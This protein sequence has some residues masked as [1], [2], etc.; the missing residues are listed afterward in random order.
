MAAGSSRALGF[1]LAAK[2]A[3]KAAVPLAAAR[4]ATARQFRSLPHV[5]NA[6]AVPSTASAIALR[7][8]PAFE[9]AGVRFMSS[10]PSHM[11]LGVWRSL[12]PASAHAELRR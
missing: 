9:A 7:R 12:A 11:E 3:A 1:R 4:V 5:A 6:P 2:S 10:L 8:R